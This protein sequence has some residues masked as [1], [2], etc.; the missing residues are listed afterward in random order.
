MNDKKLAIIATD[1]ESLESHKDFINSLLIE[2]IDLSFLIPSS[3]KN[4]IK[5]DAKY[6]FIEDL[7][8]KIP[9][10]LEFNCNSKN[11]YF[12]FLIYEALNNINEAFNAVVFISNAVDAVIPLQ[13]KKSL[14]KFQNT[15]LVV[16]NQ[17]CNADMEFEA[18]Q[19]EISLKEFVINNSLAELF[20]DKEEHFISY[21]ELKEPPKLS[22]II[23]F[24]NTGKYIE[25][26]LLSIEQNNYPNLEIIIIDDGS[27]DSYS[28]EILTKLD[29]SGKYIILHQGNKGPA[30]ARNL[31][32]SNATGKYIFLFDSD[33]TISSD[34]IE[35]S[36]DCLI[37]NPEYSYVNTNHNIVTEDDQAFLHYQIIYTDHPST[38]ALGDFLFHGV[39]KKSV[40]NNINFDETLIRHE[41]WDF[42]LNL[43]KNGHK[44]LIIPEFLY[45]YRKR[46]NSLM[47]TFSSEDREK[48]RKYVFEKHRDFFDKLSINIMKIKPWTFDIDKIFNNADFK[49]KVTEFIIENKGKKIC[50][51][52]AG[53]IAV[54]FLELYDLS[55]LDILG[56]IDGNPAKKGQKLGNYEIYSI[57]DLEELSPDILVL[58]VAQKHFVI[59]YIENIKTRNNL[60][61]QL[62]YDLF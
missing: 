56:F 62:I 53:Q 33:D 61:Y 44:G 4:S 13:A 41:D 31:G 5:I 47:N 15:N 49:Q 58:T 21:K 20:I 42:C 14:G 23:P 19:R 50:F 3:M 48:Y 18:L 2:G 36:V 6:Y 1:V 25:E 28:L 54:K 40:F 22:V 27:T 12:S 30:S 11:H 7:S 60:N 35:K 59:P 39:F 8:K 24:Y 37:N 17:A 9:Y 45:N 51:Y 43:T 16:L 55:E 52:G 57:E 32:I 26:T 10:Y 29:S 46:W 38:I 34:F